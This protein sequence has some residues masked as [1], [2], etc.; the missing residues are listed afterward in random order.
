MIPCID[1]VNH[2][3]KANSYYEPS[4]SSVALLLRPDVKLGIGE[5]ITISYGTAKSKAEMLFSYGFIE[6]GSTAK[7]MTLTLEPAPEDPLGKAKAAAFAKPPII[8]IV[9]DQGGSHW[10]SPFIYFMCLNEEDGLEFRVLQQT[11]GSRGQLKVFWQ[12]L[13][14]TN[15]T[16]NFES[17]IADHELKDVFKLRAVALLQDRIRQQLERL[18][19]SGEMV[20]SLAETNFVAPQRQ[21][22]ALQLRQSE[23]VILEKLFAVLDM[24]VSVLRKHFDHDPAHGS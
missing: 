12:G 21:R 18:F 4:A 16:D 9:E 11:D 15:S 17:H 7:G 13:D 19:E 6:E 1:M 5:E 8:Q 24:Q 2:S 14:V 23:I 20:G 10:D 3:S 22:N